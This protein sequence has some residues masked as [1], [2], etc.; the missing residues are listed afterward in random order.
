MLET[1]VTMFVS[2]S[3]THE[4]EANYQ[5]MDRIQKFQNKSLRS[6][7]QWEFNLCD[8]KLTMDVAP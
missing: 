5:V 6:A 1:Q 2:S 8:I 3:H 7:C 4:G